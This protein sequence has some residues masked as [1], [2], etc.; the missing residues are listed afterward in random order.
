MYTLKVY[1]QNSS[2]YMP[3]L[4]YT[5]CQFN[6]ADVRN[7]A[8]VSSCLLLNGITAV[9]CPP[10][11]APGN[12][13]LL[14]LQH[15]AASASW[16]ELQS[17]LPCTL[18]SYV[19]LLCVGSG[20]GPRMREPNLRPPLHP[21]QD[22]VTTAHASKAATRTKDCSRP[23]APCGNSNTNAFVALSFCNRHRLPG[24]HP[25]DVCSTKYDCSFSADQRGHDS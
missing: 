19:M 25:G 20:V 8:G 9:T 2:L 14:L 5:T 11:Q 18:S 24:L 10:A 3:A 21:L 6:A 12:S 17:H 23:P 15:G 4:R 16:L 1:F 7:S 13:R 22:P